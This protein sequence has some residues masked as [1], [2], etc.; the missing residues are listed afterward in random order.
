MSMTALVTVNDGIKEII[1]AVELA[2]E[3]EMGTTTTALMNMANA[4]QTAMGR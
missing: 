3:T 1:A 2:A 4:M